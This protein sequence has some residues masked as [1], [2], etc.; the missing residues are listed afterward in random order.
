MLPIRG[1]FLRYFSYVPE[2]AKEKQCNWVT[3][4]AAKQKKKTIEV[5]CIGNF[6]I[7]NFGTPQ[8]RIYDL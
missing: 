8:K 4:K 6:V 3:Q 2:N 5:L 1:R 7:W